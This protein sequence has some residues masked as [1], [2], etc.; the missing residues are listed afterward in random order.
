MS[1]YTN[2][3]AA[4]R[5][6]VGPIVLEE[7]LKLLEQQS[8]G[9]D[10]L[11]SGSS[12][13]SFINLFGELISA[14]TFGAVAD[15]STDDSAALTAYFTAMQGS[16]R[17]AL[18]APSANSYHITSPVLIPLTGN[19]HVDF[20]F[21]RIT[22]APGAYIKFYRPVSY[23]LTL[24]GNIAAGADSFTVSSAAS[25]SEGD[26]ILLS[27]NVTAENTFSSKAN[28]TVI[29]KSISGNTITTTDIIKMP[30]NTTD[31]GLVVNGYTQ[32]G[33][34]KLDN[35]NGR[36][37][38]ATAST[39]PILYLEGLH[40]PVIS[41]PRLSSNYGWQADGNQR[42][43][44]LWLNICIGALVQGARVKHLSY[45]I[46]STSGGE[47][48]VSEPRGNGCRHPVFVGTWCNGAEIVELT[49]A[50]NYGAIDSHA[51]FN[52]FY[53]GGQTRNSQT[54]PN[55]R[56]IGGGI[57]GHKYHM[58][59]GDS[60][61]GPYFHN[62]ALVNNGVGL[63]TGVNLELVDFSV[64]SPNRTKSV[65]GGSFGNIKARNCRANLVEVAFLATLDSLEI[66]NCRNWD[67]TPWGRVGVRLSPT[68]VAQPLVAAT[69]ASSVYHIDP[70]AALVQQA[71]GNLRCSGPIV[72]D[73][74]GSPQALTVR[75]HTN[76][77]PATDSQTYI[78]GVIRFTGFVRHG[79]SGLGDIQS[80]KFHFI[81]KAG[82]GTSAVTFP[83]TAAQTDGATGQSN[84]DLTV[85]ISAPTQSGFTQVGAGG[86]YYVEL[87]VTLTSAK[88]TPIF[89]LS[90]D[91]E[92]QAMT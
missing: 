17:R 43:W 52:V 46:V 25:V 31:T 59:G 20:Q 11:L 51:A 49:G 65:I 6:K 69:L 58:Y 44:G 38:G 3:V 66:L 12:E 7:I 56:C 54:L 75:I 24:S 91:L 70:Y 5:K 53:R 61:L 37:I 90:Y 86:D 29:V 4:L 55:M 64:N 35:F 34:L 10:V 71:G 2:I 76:V 85:V 28:A 19:L 33:K 27:T 81:H 50:N 68:I 80:N 67:G 78:C 36:L 41:Q 30:I 23:T 16:G 18:F 8:F 32:P 87:V 73:L 63:Y 26:L 72:R 89:A 77:F 45:G 88:T 47:V 83:T 40:E 82:V 39:D 60:E 79:T 13:V 22:V 62:L 15:G 42:G 74:S 9:E 1:N 92:L 14:K 57:F 84:E 48:V 21:A